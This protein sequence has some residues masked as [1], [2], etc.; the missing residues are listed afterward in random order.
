[1]WSSVVVLSTAL[2]S[3]APSLATASTARAASRALIVGR[4]VELLSTYDYI[5]AG[6]GAAG[7]TVADRLTENSRGTRLAVL[8]DPMC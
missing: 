2:A 7:L 3:F 5:I 6:A 4:D 8:H 1:M